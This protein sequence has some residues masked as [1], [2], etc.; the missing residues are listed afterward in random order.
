MVYEPVTGPASSQAQSPVSGEALT[1]AIAEKRE[2][3][4]RKFEDTFNLEAKV[5]YWEH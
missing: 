2:A 1:A 4:D 5:T 3:F